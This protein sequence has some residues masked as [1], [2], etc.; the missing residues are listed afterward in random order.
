MAESNWYIGTAKQMWWNLNGRLY[1]V[2]GQWDKRNGLCTWVILISVDQNW[3]Y[4]IYQIFETRS[5]KLT[6][7]TG[8]VFGHYLVAAILRYIWELLYCQNVSR[9]NNTY[10]N[11]PLIIMHGMI[12]SKRSKTP[13]KKKLLPKFGNKTIC[14]YNNS[15]LSVSTKWYEGYFLHFNFLKPDFINIL[16]LT[17]FISMHGNRS[18][19]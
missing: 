11:C 4:T 17:N 18:F 16:E 8:F 15:S 12:L 19:V 10:S 1:F 7:G 3:L 6:G 2:I 14:R 13:R 9:Q 5:M